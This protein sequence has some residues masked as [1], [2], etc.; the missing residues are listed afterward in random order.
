MKRQNCLNFVVGFSTPRTMKLRGTI[1]NQEVMVLIDCGASHNFSAELVDKLRL[2][3]VGTHS[4]RVLLGTELS[5]KGVGW[6]TSS[7]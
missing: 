6:Q 2:P 3:S 1:A 4:F 5:V 7:L